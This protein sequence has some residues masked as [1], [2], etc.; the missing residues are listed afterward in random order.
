MTA[1][2]R[3]KTTKKITVGERERDLDLKQA[4]ALEHMKKSGKLR[5]R[6]RNGAREKLESSVKSLIEALGPEA[7]AEALEAARKLGI[8]VD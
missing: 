7:R 2:A 8:K 4:E 3:R 1:P 6:L 5:Q